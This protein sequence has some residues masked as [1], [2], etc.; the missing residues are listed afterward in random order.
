M[1][2]LV[3]SRSTRSGAA[4]VEFAVVLP[5]LAFV[6]AAVVDFARVFAAAQVLSTAAGTGVQYA[7]GYHWVPGQND[8]AWSAAA[9]DAVVNAGATLVPPLERGS[10]SVKQTDGN[11]TVS[12]TY[13]M[14][15]IMDVLYQDKKTTLQRTLTLR[16]APRP[17]D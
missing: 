17:G 3:Q 2:V 13:D 7:A 16:K 11:A 9:T 6:I 5:F 10:V 12:V 14:N 4:A 15:L 1:L 8:D